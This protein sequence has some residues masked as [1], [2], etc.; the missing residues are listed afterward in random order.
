MVSLMMPFTKPF[1]KISEGFFVEKLKGYGALIQ[2][3]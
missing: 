3:F 1:G 2:G